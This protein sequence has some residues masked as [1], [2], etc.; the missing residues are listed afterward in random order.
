MQ[1]YDH[2]VYKFDQWVGFPEA[3]ETGNRSKAV[4]LMPR[5]AAGVR[6]VLD[7][8]QA[9]AWKANVLSDFCR[10]RWKSDTW[11]NVHGYDREFMVLDALTASKES[12]CVLPHFLQIT[13]FYV[14]PHVGAATLATRIDVAVLRETVDASANQSKYDYTSRVVPAMLSLALFVREDALKV[15]WYAM[16]RA[17]ATRDTRPLDDLLRDPRVCSQLSD[18]LRDMITRLYASLALHSPPFT[19]VHDAYDVSD[20]VA[21]CDMHRLRALQPKRD[22]NTVATP[23]LAAPSFWTTHAHARVPETDAQW[24]EWLAHGSDDL[25]TDNDALLH[26]VQQGNAAVV[27]RLLQR[28]RVLL[29]CKNFVAVRAAMA[30]ERADCLRL[31]LDHM[32]NEDS[33]FYEAALQAAWTVAPETAAHGTCLDVVLEVLN[34]AA[35]RSLDV[36]VA[37]NAILWGA[38]RTGHQGLVAALAKQDSVYKSLPSC[39]DTLWRNR[40]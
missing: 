13:Q 7:A 22:G 15:V 14:K 31:L 30:K 8:P 29:P 4:E 18:T 35:P 24:N 37:G 20:A 6:R 33:R 38:V 11:F 3:L 19:D 26:G 39:T 28:G 10:C 21:S 12:M 16:E 27:N 25:M 9:P 1:L 40:E 5:S 17:W 2:V 23:A 34:R 36:S 32:R